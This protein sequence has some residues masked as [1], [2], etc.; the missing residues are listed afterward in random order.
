MGFERVFRDING[1]EWQVS[2]VTPTS[3]STEGWLSFESGHLERRLMPVP[4]GWERVTIQRLEQMCRIATPIQRDQ[5][6][7]ASNDSLTPADEL[8]EP[9]LDT[10]SADAAGTLHT[11]ADD[12][13]SVLAN[14]WPTHPSRITFRG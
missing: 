3:S 6:M 14:A 9:T 7:T 5:S 12:H 4:K 11:V 13:V 2:F 1:V 10:M 8:P